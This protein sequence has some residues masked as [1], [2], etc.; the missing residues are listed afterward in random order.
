[1]GSKLLSA[2]RLEDSSRLQGGAW[3]TEVVEDVVR[4]RS[5]AWAARQRSTVHR[6][7]HKSLDT[8]SSIFKSWVILVQKTGR[9]ELIVVPII[10]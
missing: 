4:R 1:M 8:E 7:T 10:P 3:T 5:Q 9:L 6:E 2:R